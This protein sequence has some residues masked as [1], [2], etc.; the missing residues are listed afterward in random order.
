M[1]VSLP[2]REKIREALPTSSLNFA[3]RLKEKFTFLKKINPTLSNDE[4]TARQRGPF[5]HVYGGT[6]HFLEPYYMMKELDG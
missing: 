5:I 1:E 2:T 4:N 3:S 6:V